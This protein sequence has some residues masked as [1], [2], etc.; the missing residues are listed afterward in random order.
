MDPHAAIADAIEELGT[1]FPTRQLLH[2]SAGAGSALGDVDRLLQLVGNL[3]AN[4]VAYGEP[5]RP[6]TVTSS[7]TESG[8][9]IAVHNFGRPIDEKTLATLFQ[10]MV[11]GES[12]IGEASS[13]GLGLYIVQSIAKAHGGAVTVA[14]SEVDGTTFTATFPAP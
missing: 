13:V 12:G 6:I 4:A 3:V 14:S 7:I 11:R 10:P 9:F 2:K 8:F 5:G 1:A